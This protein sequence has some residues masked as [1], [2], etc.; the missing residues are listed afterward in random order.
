MY[1]GSVSFSGSDLDNVNG[2]VVNIPSGLNNYSF[3]QGLNSSQ[4]SLVYDLVNIHKDVYIS[5]NV[6][7]LKI[8]NKHNKLKS[9]LSKVKSLI[10]L[11][12]KVDNDLY[13][14]IIIKLLLL[15]KEIKN[16]KKLID[17]YEKAMNY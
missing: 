14:Q 9:K 4:Y 17:Q 10:L 15:N 11:N 7:Y 12:N 16:T 1:N 5:K 13:N 6:N 3:I 2:V 8:V